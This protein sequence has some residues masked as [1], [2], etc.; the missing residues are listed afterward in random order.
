[1]TRGFGVLFVGRLTKM[2]VGPVAY[3]L[4]RFRMLMGHHCY[5]AIHRK[6]ARALRKNGLQHSHRLFLTNI[7]STQVLNSGCFFAFIIESVWLNISVFYSQKENHFS[8]DDKIIFLQID[9]YWNFSLFDIRILCKLVRHFLTSKPLFKQIILIA[10]RYFK[11][12]A[13]RG[14]LRY[15]VEFTILARA[16][17][18]IDERLT[19]SVI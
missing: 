16:W 13:L 17:L 5:N 6:T 1:M 10:V 12:P 7:T 4:R 9:V 11:Q 14:R 8:K 19:G 3:D 18:A 2:T 15:S